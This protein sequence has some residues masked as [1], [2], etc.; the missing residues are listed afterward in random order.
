MCRWEARHRPGDA[1]S[2][3]HAR[4]R[5]MRH[6]GTATIMWAWADLPIRGPRPR[7]VRPHRLGAPLQTAGGPMNGS[8]C[9][10]S[11]SA[12]RSRRRR[13]GFRWSPAVLT[14]VLCAQ[15]GLE[16]PHGI[17][18]PHS[19]KEGGRH[20]DQSGHWAAHLGCPVSKICCQAEGLVQ[21]GQAAG[22]SVG[23]GCPASIRRVQQPRNISH[24]P[25][26]QSACRS[27][28]IS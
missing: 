14:D 19:A 28:E 15:I 2:G 20:D 26:V 24:V 7:T 11:E 27:R 21:V 9:G 16:F 8:C 10:S 3:W 22:E 4:C 23:C 17:G 13:V 5:G 6:P 1:T 18:R 25:T 12:H